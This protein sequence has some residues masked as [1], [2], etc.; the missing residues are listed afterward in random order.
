MVIRFMY[1]VLFVP[2]IV[3]CPILPKQIWFDFHKEVNALK[4]AESQN[5]MLPSTSFYHSSVEKHLW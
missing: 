1:S 4:V 3:I 5:Q 2:F